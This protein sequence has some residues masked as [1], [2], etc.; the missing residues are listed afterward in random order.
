MEIQGWRDPLSELDLESRLASF[1]AAMRALWQHYRAELDSAAYFAMTLESHML[2]RDVA[3]RPVTRL[4]GRLDLSK[5]LGLEGVSLCHH[6][7]APVVVRGWNAQQGLPKEDEPA[8]GR[9]ST[10]LFRIEPGGEEAVLE[11]LTLIEAE[12][13]G[14]RRTQGFGRLRICD[15]F[16]YDFVLREMRGAS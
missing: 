1:N 16:H 10:L 13:L 12:G 14:R 8:L 11:R 7:I 15:P 6:V 2:L 3:G 9:G 5:L 4:E